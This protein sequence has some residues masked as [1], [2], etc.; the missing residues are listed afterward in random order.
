MLVTYVH[1][2]D[3]QLAAE[4]VAEED[5]RTCGALLVDPA[6]PRRDNVVAFSLGIAMVRGRP[7]L[8]RSS[9][10]IRPPR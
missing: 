1:G 4:V 10:A 3:D 9:C 2:V 7:A 5:R 6:F 8:P